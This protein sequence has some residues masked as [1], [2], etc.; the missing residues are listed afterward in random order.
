MARR[1]ARPNLIIGHVGSNEARIW[2]RGGPEHPVAY[3]DYEQEGSGASTSAGPLRLEERHDYTGL[4]NLEQLSPSTPYKCKVTFA[5][6]ENTPT[7]ERRQPRDST[8]TFQ[9]A[10]L[11]GA[12]TD[13]CFLLGSCNL[14]SLGPVSSPDPAFR[15]IAKIIKEQNVNFMIHCGDQIYS[16]I[17]IPTTPFFSFDI[18]QY[19]SKYVDAWGDSQPTHNV[20]RMIPHYMILDDHEIVNDFANDIKLFFGLM[21]VDRLKDVAVKAYRE[22]QHLHNPQSYGHDVL[23]YNFSYGKNRFFVMDT[24]TER[25]QKTKPTQ[26]ISHLQLER[27][28]AWLKEFPD[29]LKFVVSSVPFVADLRFHDDDKWCSPPFLGQREEIIKFIGQ[30]NVQNVVFLT[31]DMHCSYQAH[32]E[33]ST[34][35]NKKIAVHELMS[36]PINQLGKSPISAYYTSTESKLIDGSQIRYSTQLEEDKFYNAHSNVMCIQVSGRVVR[37]QLYRTK[38][39]KST[40]VDGAIPL[41]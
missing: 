37:F 30:N 8:G 29:D 28:L 12:E 35:D 36:S 39:D 1:K 16:D 31:G 23:Y 34:G 38:S 10:P 40:N 20:L 13:V 15:Q 17:P 5:A 33:V 24:R 27:F 9:T 32:M 41:V 7:S 4:F 2:V 19:R 18:D 22:Y 11:E 3:L 21:D 26:M 25:Y 6:A 14:H